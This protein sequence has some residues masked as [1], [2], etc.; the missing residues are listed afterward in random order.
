MLHESA[1]IFYSRCK[2]SIFS[3]TSEC[4]FVQKTTTRALNIYLILYPPNYQDIMH[5][6]GTRGAPMKT[7]KT[8]I[9]GAIGGAIVGFFI[10]LLGFMGDSAHLPN[11]KYVPH[12]SLLIALIPVGAIV[13]AFIAWTN[14]GH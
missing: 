3:A 12:P 4:N 13:G 10:A 14:E 2:V 8:L 6:V 1:R 11:Y 9:G 7:L 5:A